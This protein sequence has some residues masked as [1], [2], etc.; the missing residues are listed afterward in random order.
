MDIQGYL[1]CAAVLAS[2]ILSGILTPYI[3]LV[4]LTKRKVDKLD[5]RKIHN[6][7]TPRLGGLLFFP[8]LFI[9]AF[10]IWL[11]YLTSYATM[12]RSVWLES[13][14]HLWLI[15]LALL[16]SYFIGVADDLREMDYRAKFA[17]QFLVSILLVL[18]GLNISDL[19]GVADL[20]VLPTSVS[21]LLTIV[22]I[23]LVVNSINLIDG[24]DGLAAGLGGIALLY[25]GCFFFTLQNFT[26]ALMAFAM[27]GVVLS[28]FYYNIFG[29][30]KRTIFMGD[31]GAISLGVLLVILAIR[32][33]IQLSQDTG[34]PGN[35]LVLAFV[36]LLIPGLDLIRVFIHRI[37]LHKHPFKPDKNHIHHKMLVLGVSQ[38]ETLGIILFLSFVYI[39]SNVLMTKSEMPVNLILAVDIISY[40]L[41]NIRLTQKIK[42]Q[43]NIIK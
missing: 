30:K 35:P 10:P 31:T 4:S 25:Y 28:F 16:I 29:Y 1:L 13:L 32:L 11:F 15:A 9:S 17:G 23:M 26:Y 7:Y 3:L 12:V 2:I 19:A 41:L 38:H 18:A 37:R 42:R 33:S 6:T 5:E 40:T 14:P 39:I 34:L 43:K 27:F 36:P 24:I 21:I 20:Y 22:V 8:V